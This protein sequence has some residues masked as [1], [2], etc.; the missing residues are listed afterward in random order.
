MKAILI[1]GN[2]GGSPTD[3]WFPYLERELSMRGVRVINV[4]FPDAI[5][6]RK[7]YWLPF[8]EKL[9]A[10]EHTV[11]IGHSSGAVAAMRYAETHKIMGSVL[12]GACYT[13]LGYDTEKQS[14]YY[15]TSWDWKAIKNNQQWI[16]QFSSSDDPW[17]PIEQAQYIHAQLDTEYYEYIDRGHF[18]GDKEVKEFPE[19]IEKLL[20]HLL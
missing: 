2:G 18:G 3:N 7:E 16:I 5:L 14:G 10:D 11:L 1:P 6:A 19:L 17:I 15:D 12:V 20:Q 9:G 13:D 8:I 4:Q